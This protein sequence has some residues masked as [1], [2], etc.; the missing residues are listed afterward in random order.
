MFLTDDELVI[1]TPYNYFNKNQNTRI[2]LEDLLKERL[3]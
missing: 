2:T 3:I 1:V